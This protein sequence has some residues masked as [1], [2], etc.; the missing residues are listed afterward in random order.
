MFNQRSP[1]LN[2]PHDLTGFWVTEDHYKTNQVW[3]RGPRQSPQLLC[4]YQTAMPPTLFLLF[5]HPKMS[6]KW[7][8]YHWTLI[9]ILKLKDKQIGRDLAT[10]SASRWCR[11]ALHIAGCKSAPITLWLEAPKGPNL[12]PMTLAG[13]LHGLHTPGCLP[14]PFIS[15]LSPFEY[16]HV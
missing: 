4:C 3:W 16:Q 11:A 6:T 15:F 2:A 13:D 12:W 1:A 14:V 10:R 5:V 8:N 9:K 7:L